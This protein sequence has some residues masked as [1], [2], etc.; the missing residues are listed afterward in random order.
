MR[1]LSSWELRLTAVPN[2]IECSE[3]RLLGFADHEPPAFAGPG[4]INIRSMTSIDF[5]MFGSATDESDA[6]R[7]LVQA[8]KNPYAVHDQF[9]LFAIDFDGHEWACGMPTV[10]PVSSQGGRWLL[11]GELSFMAT[12]VSGDWVS[13]EAGVELVFVPKL[14]LQME[15]PMVS[16]TTIA[17]EEVQTSRESGRQKLQVLGSEI[18]FS[19]W[20]ES[21]ALYV[22][23]S[24]S[25]ELRHPYMDG[26]LSEPLRILAG[27]PIYPRLVARNMGDGTA[28]VWLRSSPSRLKRAG[29]ASFL[30][31][32]PAIA[33]PKFWQA[34]ASLLTLIARA[35]DSNGHQDLEAHRLTR[36]YDEIIEATQGSRWV[37]CLTLASSAEGIAREIMRPEERKSDFASKDICALKKVVAAWDGDRGLRE[38]IVSDISKAGQRGIGR[39]LRDLVERSVVTAEQERAWSAVR[40]QVMHGNLVSPWGSEDEDQRLMNLAGLVHRLTEELIRRQVG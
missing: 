6:F 4:R 10:N 21:D 19:Y 17:G 26:W 40:N 31:K 30:G 35:R 15:Q 28:Q 36:Y 27:Q 25:E 20:P 39:F 2:T 16:I 23:A 37:L 5:A 12:H 7:R 14:D 8:G 11:T 9:R 3:M 24:A 34:Y 1:T 38:R 32:D 18:T 29:L 33:G 22:T 13:K